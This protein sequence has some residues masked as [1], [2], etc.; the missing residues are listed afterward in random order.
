[1]ADLSKY[2]DYNATTPV[3]ATARRVWQD[4]AENHWHNPSSLYR[5]AGGAKHLLEHCRE[6]LA[7]LLGLDE[8]ERIVFTSGATESNNALIRTLVE[9][10]SGIVAVSAIEH[11]SLSAPCDA[12]VPEGRQA[13]LPVHSDTGAVSVNETA[14]LVSETGVAAVSVLAANNETGALQ[15]WEEL[16]GLCREKGVLFHTD[17]AQWIGKLSSGDLGKCDFVTGSAHKFGGPK[18]TGFLVVPDPEEWTDFHASIGGPQE[19]GRR[20]GTENLPAIAAMVEALKEL[21]Q[22]LTEGFRKEQATARDSFE[23]QCAESIGTRV[24]GG[25]GDRLWNTSMI[26]LPHTKNLKWLT[27]LSQRGFCVS[28]GSACSAGKG[29]PSLVMQAMGL[30]FDEMGRVLRFS[31]GWNSAPEDWEALASTLVEIDTELKG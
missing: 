30:D 13:I 7:D 20:A 15:P 31:S 9:K 16:A 12:W 29:N 14:G 28:T 17:A 23:T 2:F 6:E 3:S 18:G 5:E 21:D 1:M 8:P 27:R 10:T 4:T 22:T 24:V 26:V 11:P 19:D 25:A